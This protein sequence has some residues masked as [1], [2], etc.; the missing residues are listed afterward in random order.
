MHSQLPSVRHQTISSQDAPCSLLVLRIS[1]GQQSVSA[2]PLA[3]SAPS[4]PSLLSLWFSPWCL[5][6]TES[7]FTE[8]LLCANQR[9]RSHD[10]PKNEVNTRDYALLITGMIKGPFAFLIFQSL[11]KF[12]RNTGIIL[13]Y[14][15]GNRIGRS[16]VTCPHHQTHI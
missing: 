13:P 14:R 6:A 11:S 9:V 5:P 4:H 2:D 3:G 10:R 1:G 15:W 16:Y 12:C 7:V 8:H